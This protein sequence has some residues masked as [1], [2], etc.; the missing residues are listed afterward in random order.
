MRDQLDKKSC[1][2]VIG[3]DT[4]DERVLTS[5]PYYRAPYVFIQRKNS[6]LDI[7]SWDSPDLKKAEQDRHGAG[8]PG[9][10]DAGEARRSSTATSTT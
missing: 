2:V 10:G 1:D 3:L 5:K 4:G 9:A 6:K 8:Q 7:T